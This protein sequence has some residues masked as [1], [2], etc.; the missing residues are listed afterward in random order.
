MA[1]KK[2]IT[3]TKT[4]E[5]QQ[6]KGNPDALV[7]LLVIML[8]NAIKYSSEKGT[9]AI[10]AQKTKYHVTLEIHDVGIGIKPRE[11]P[12]IFDRFYRAD[13]ARSTSGN[14][15]GYGLG[16]SI[17]KKIVDT[18]HGSITVKS[19]QVKGTTFIIKLPIRQ[20]PKARTS[21]FT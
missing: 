8:D 14:K 13:T 11:I 12:H 5:K 6:F 15:N 17:A 4:S 21:L 19:T 10:T 7:D 16:L 18:H 9:V 3:I 1:K 2:N 20:V